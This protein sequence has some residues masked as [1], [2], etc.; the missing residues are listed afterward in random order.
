MGNGK[1]IWEP[2]ITIKMDE[3]I[4]YFKE[5]QTNYI[6]LKPNLNFVYLVNGVR[7]NGTMDYML[8]I[9]PLHQKSNRYLVIE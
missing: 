7:P 4:F 9:Q 8:N 2:N 5:I 1:F 6:Y 3:G